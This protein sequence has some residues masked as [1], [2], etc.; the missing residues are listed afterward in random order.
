LAAGAL[1]K[2]TQDKF[3]LLIELIPS[4]FKAPPDLFGMGATILKLV[5]SESDKQSED[6]QS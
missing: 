4:L 3:D 1:S 6:D 5:N 2:L